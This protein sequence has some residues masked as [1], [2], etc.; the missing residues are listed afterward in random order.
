MERRG[1]GNVSNRDAAFVRLVA[2]L[3]RLGKQSKRPIKRAELIRKLGPRAI[4]QLEAKGILKP[5]GEGYLIDDKV[6]K[7][8]RRNT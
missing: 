6:V 5:S 7:T 2:E 8:I 1:D 4:K 3:W